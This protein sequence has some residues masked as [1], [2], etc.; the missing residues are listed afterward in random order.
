MSGYSNEYLDALKA[1]IDRLTEHV[2][3]YKRDLTRAKQLVPDDHNLIAG[4]EW[5][6]EDSRNALL[7]RILQFGPGF[8]CASHPTHGI[9]KTV[10]GLGDAE[11]HA[12]DTLHG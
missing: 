12:G 3:R 8:G 9:Y 11:L 1:E 2:E 4:L 7:I 5:A 10:I 6:L